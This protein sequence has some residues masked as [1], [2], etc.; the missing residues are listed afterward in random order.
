MATYN[1]KSILEK[2]ENENPV[3]TNTKNSNELDRSSFILPESE[4]ENQSLP[5]E[6]DAKDIGE[7]ALAGAADT[8][9]FL[10]DIPSMIA[11]GTD[12]VQQKVIR[13]SALKAVMYMGQVLGADENEMKIMETNIK[14]SLDFAKKQEK[15]S[16]DKLAVGTTIN[17]AAQKNNVYPFNYESKTAGGKIVKTA[18]EYALPSLLFAPFGYGKVMTATGFASGAID[19]AITNA[20][21]DMAGTITGVG[22]NITA[23]ILALKKGNA[24]QIAKRITDSFSKEEL[25]TAAKLQ[26]VAKADGIDLKVSDVLEGSVINKYETDVMGTEIGMNIVE[27]FWKTRPPQL[28]KYIKKWAKENGLISNQKVLSESEQFQ[29]IKN[30]AIGLQTNRN[31]LW[32]KAGGNDIL[33]F[34][35]P[36]QSVDNLV[37]EAKNI[38]KN[39]DNATLNSAMNT[40]ITMLKKSDGQGKNLHEIYREIRDIGNDLSSNLQKSV[41]DKQQVKAFKTMENMLSETMS[42]NPAFKKAQDTYKIFTSEKIEK[43][44][45]KLKFF[46]DVRLAKDEIYSN[47]ELTAKMYKFFGSD[48]VSTKDIKLMAESFAES[49]KVTKGMDAKTIAK[50]EKNQDAWR[51][52]ISGYF[53]SNFLQAHSKGLEKGLKDGDIMYRAMMNSKIKRDNFT[54]MLFQLAKQ[55]DKS[56]QKIDIQ[57]AFDSFATILKSTGAKPSQ[58][59]NTFNKFLGADELG[60]NKISQALGT[61]GGIPFTEMISKFF[62]NNMKSKTSKIIADALTSPDGIND[63]I[64][65][66]KGWRDPDNAKMFAVNLLKL[67][68]S[69]EILEENT[70]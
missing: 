61:K 5:M 39:S 28:K 59:S 41:S 26:K 69:D 19:G 57:K 52:L 12:F 46:K 43:G 24:K 18:V 21:N 20:G 63:L 54:E 38:V 17:E 16:N 50:I 36:S 55:E 10:L 13:P 3:N 47:Q 2:W 7:S 66:S 42:T 35:Y 56:I 14:K 45:D 34:Y 25:E 4:T 6:F 22:L 31:W 23:D 60:D 1:Y 67:G 32:G 65:L 9:T 8:V 64:K 48:K 51:E 11:K 27:K 58:G 30:V 70:Q 53:E 33:K 15:I 40:Y 68:T 49:A 37:I 29:N 62:S 44:F